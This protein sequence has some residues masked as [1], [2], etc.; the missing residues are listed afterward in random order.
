MGVPTL[1]GVPT[2]DEG[3]LTWTGIPTL[4]GGTYSGG[5]GATYPGWGYLPWMIGWGDG[6]PTLDRRWVPIL[7]GRGTYHGGTY[8]QQ[9]AGTYPGWGTYLGRVYLP[10]VDT[11]HQ[12]EGRYPPPLLVGR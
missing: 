1:A 4:D 11:P 9:G 2:L 8:H 6:V 12:L 3:Y 10:K 7:V 5:E